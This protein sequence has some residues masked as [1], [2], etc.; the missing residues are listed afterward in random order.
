MK[1]NDDYHILENVTVRR[2][3]SPAQSIGFAGEM[4]TPS[5]LA[6]RGSTLKDWF[7]EKATE[8]VGSFGMQVDDDTD[9]QKNSGGKVSTGQSVNKRVKR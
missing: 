5:L 1:V 3:F 7:V 4:A 8:F 9:G 2:W 6:L